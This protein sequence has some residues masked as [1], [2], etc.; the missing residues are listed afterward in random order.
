MRT[1]L[2]GTGA[3][4]LL[5]AAL[6][7]PVKAS[8]RAVVVK[9]GFCMLLDGNGGMVEAS[10]SISV[11][12]KNGWMFTCKAKDVPN[13]THHEVRYDSISTGFPCM[14]TN[15]STNDWQE[16]VSASGNA[17]LSCHANDDK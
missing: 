16:T 6:C 3:A 1:A 11:T 9:D 15:G 2:S 4:V 14:T 5:I 10:D 17:T 8:D 13:T 7:V 12:H